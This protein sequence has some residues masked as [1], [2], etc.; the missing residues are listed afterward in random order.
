MLIGAFCLFSFALA[1]KLLAHYEGTTLHLDIRSV[2]G[3]IAESQKGDVTIK[4]DWISEHV[5]LWRRTT[6]VIHPAK[7]P[8]ESATYA[9]RHRK[10]TP[11]PVVDHKADFL[12]LHNKDDV[13]CF[14]HM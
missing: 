13:I 1:R 11:R 9:L 3:K 12:R 7:A 5:D 8:T 14:V 4:P 6:I 10:A 2:L